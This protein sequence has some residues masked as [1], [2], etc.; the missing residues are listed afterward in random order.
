MTSAATYVKH[1][2]QQMEDQV[3]QQ[4]KQQSNKMHLQLLAFLLRK[5]FASFNNKQNWSHFISISK[6]KPTSS[7]QH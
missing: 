7:I 3:H 2:S 4:L 1:I 5:V 6:C